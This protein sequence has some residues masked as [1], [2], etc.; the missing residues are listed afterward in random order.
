MSAGM[1]GHPAKPCRAATI[2]GSRRVLW[3][4]DEKTL[5]EDEE[6]NNAGNL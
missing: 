1:L 5:V 3:G 4:K 2:G 6:Q